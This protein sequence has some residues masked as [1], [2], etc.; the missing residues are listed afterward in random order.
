MSSDVLANFTCLDELTQ[1]IYQ[2]VHRFVVLST[3]SN[4]WTVHLGLSGPEGRWWRGTWAKADI[5]EIVGSKS[6]DKLLEAFAEKLAETFIQGELYVGDW[7]PEKDAKIKLTLGP[8]SK[9]PLHIPLVE[10]SSAEAASH[11]TDVLL[12]VSANK[13][14]LNHLIV[15]YVER[16]RFKLSQGNAVFIQTS[17]RRVMCHLN[18][19]Q[20]DRV[21]TGR[22]LFDPAIATTTSVMAPSN[23]SR[24]GI[25]SPQGALPVDVKPQAAVCTDGHTEVKASKAKLEKPNQRA[26]STDPK[27]APK[28]LKGASLANP[29]KKARKYQAIEFESDE[30]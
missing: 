12:D 29:N 18:P 7:S 11:A 9:K 3:V 26:S 19:Q 25:P 23:T 2:G 8:S 6:S 5:L 16:L 28:Q 13:E 4:Q 20:T 10:L 15:Y 14:P 30:E 1:V 17:L 24:R 27:I 21:L 22:I